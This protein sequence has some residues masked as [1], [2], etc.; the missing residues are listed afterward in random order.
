MIM[1]MM[2]KLFKLYSIANRAKGIN[3][4]NF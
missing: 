3:I 1:I 2:I 4:N